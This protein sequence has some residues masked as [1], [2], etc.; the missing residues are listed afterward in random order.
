MELYKCYPPPPKKVKL[1][2]AEAGCRRQRQDMPAG[3]DASLRSACGRPPSLGARVRHSASDPRRRQASRRREARA[4]GP[5]G[6]RGPRRSRPLGHRYHPATGAGR[7]APSRGA[8]PPRAP[9]APLDTG[10]VTR[11]QRSGTPAAAS[12]LPA[13][14]TNPLTAEA[15]RQRCPARQR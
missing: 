14:A 13:Q 6:A 4:A 8:P 9:W 2:S 7:R 3:Y 11:P 10:I 1:P 15:V 5:P 12:L